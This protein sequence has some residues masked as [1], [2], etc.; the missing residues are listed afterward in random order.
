PL[1]GDTAPAQTQRY[2][3]Y[4]TLVGSWTFG[5][6]G[7]EGRQE[8]VARHVEYFEK[9]S[10]EAKEQTSWTSPHQAYDA[11]VTKFVGGMLDDEGFLAQVRDFCQKIEPYGAA[12]ALSQALLR[13]TVPGI[14]D[15]YQGS[16][17]WNQTL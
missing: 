2:L 14:P 10:R 4:Q 7:K 11:A 3:F 8:F 17:L 1:D 6:D 16:E 13:A 5:W 12:N 15:T 9:A